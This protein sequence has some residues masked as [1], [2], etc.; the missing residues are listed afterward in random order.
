MGTRTQRER[1]DERDMELLRGSN[2][3]PLMIAIT[4]RDLDGALMFI[5][6]VKGRDLDVMN[7][8]GRNALMLA[9]MLRYTTEEE[10]TPKPDFIEKIVEALIE[11]GASLNER[12]DG[13]TALW[14]AKTHGLPSVAR[15]LERN[16]AVE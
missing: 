8:V 5:R 12:C 11:K 7:S 1:I 15:I 14:Y 16:G 4:K 9:S 13:N 6:K 2:F 3:T 10:K